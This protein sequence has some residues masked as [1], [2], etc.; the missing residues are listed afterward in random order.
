MFPFDSITDLKQYL[1]EEKTLVLI[2]KPTTLTDGTILRQCVAGGDFNPAHC[3][4]KFSKYSFFKG[5]V[6]HGIGV[7]S[8][9]EG[10]F[11]QMIQFQEN[12]VELITRGYDKIR[13]LSPLR[14]G[15]RYWYKFTISELRYRNGRWDCNCDIV[16]NATTPGET[17]RTIA[18]LKWLPSF[19]E[20]T[21]DVPSEK[22]SLLYP[23]SYQW[24]IWH[25]VVPF[26]LVLL[27]KKIGH[28]SLRTTLACGVIACMWYSAIS[29]VETNAKLWTEMCGNEKTS[30][31]FMTGP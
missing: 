27:G 24:N 12:P 14:L 18:S 13:Y 20:P 17:E 5:K 4:S 15:D 26:I 28:F 30:C 9:F 31:Y 10:I 1:D 16:C 3:A 11:V 2:S 29:G 6:S 21:S 8:R 19:V 7:S 22:L 25:H 23:R